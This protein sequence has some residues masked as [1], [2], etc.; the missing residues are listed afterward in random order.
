M[1]A[2]RTGFDVQ[3]QA[4]SSSLMALGMPSR[5]TLASSI[6]GTL[7]TDRLRMD[8]LGWWETTCAQE[9]AQF[10]PHS[11]ALDMLVEHWDG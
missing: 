4:S 3:S 1:E 8:L 9:L 7:T 5:E 6:F 11:S 10:D 2:E